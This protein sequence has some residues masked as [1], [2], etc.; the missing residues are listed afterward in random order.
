MIEDKKQ[1]SALCGIIEKYDEVDVS[2]E[3][4][5]RAFR[6]E[7]DPVINNHIE[8]DW[9]KKA[10]AHLDNND[11]AKMLEATR[12]NLQF[13]VLDIA[14]N[15]VEDKERLSASKFAL[16]QMGRGEVKKIE[17]LMQYEKMPAEQLIN[18]IA[19]QLLEIRKI[20]PSVNIDGLLSDSNTIEGEIVEEE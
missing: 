17:H 18:V 11:D 5:F 2:D 1:I 19:G 13:N 9:K 10:L 4:E 12:G 7:F 15:A 8:A 20:D 14:F 16:G 6:E 3:G